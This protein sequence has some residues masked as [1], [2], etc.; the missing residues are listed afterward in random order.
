MRST[1]VSMEISQCKHRL[2]TDLVS[3]AAS[4]DHI[5]HQ[6]YL[7]TVKLAIKLIDVSKRNFD[8]SG[9]SIENETNKYKEH[10]DK[11]MGLNENKDPSRNGYQI[12]S[13]SY[14][15]FLSTCSR[16]FFVLVKYCQNSCTHSGE[17]NIWAERKI[18]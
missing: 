14:P 15:N 5:L 2:A 9:R 11:Y 12:Q 7:P 1:I 6:N 17:Q 13:K 3:H 10:Q 4:I 18:K 8:V 16:L